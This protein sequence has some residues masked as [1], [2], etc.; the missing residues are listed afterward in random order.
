MRIG[1]VSDM[2]VFGHIHEEAGYRHGVEAN[3]SRVDVH[4]NPV[5]PVMEFT[6]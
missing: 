3:V 6:I 1:A 5:Y 4:Y 2:H